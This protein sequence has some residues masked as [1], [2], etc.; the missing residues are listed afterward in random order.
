MKFALLLVPLLLCA[1][2]PKVQACRQLERHGKRGEA[3]ACF[4]KLTASPDPYL[5]AE[6]HYG[7]GNFKVA[8]EDFAAA[9][10]RNPKDANVKVRFGRMM[11]EPFNKNY[12]DGGDL[13]REALEID[14]KNAEALYGLA[15]TA[16]NGFESKA[17][18][19]A[20][21]AL[22]S[23]PKM[24]E[25]QELLAQLA[26]E[27]VD[28]K[29]AV[30]EADKAIKM[31][32]D[33][34]DAYA[35]RAAVEVLEDRSP[36]QWLKKIA[37]VNP[38]YGEGHAIVA[39]HLQLNRRYDDG[40]AYYRKA[41]E[42]DPELLE[43]RSQLGINL[44]R[45]GKEVEA[46]EQLQ[47]AYDAGF[48]ESSTTNSLKLIDSYKKFVTYK[49]PVSILKLDKKEADVL[50]I[51]F[52]QELL[53][54]ISTYDKKYKV[55]LPVPVQLEVYPN[56]EDFAVRTMG[57]PGLGAL[58]VTFGTVVAMD[59]PSGRKPGAFHWAGTLWHEMSHVYVLSATR[60][61][62]PRWFTEGVAVHEESAI[63]P[64][65]GDR[66]TPDIIM[67]V[68]DK[69][70]LPVAE[71]DRG[72]IRPNYPN[73]VIVSYYQ[74]GQII[75][76]I[77]ER[78]GWDKVLAMMN[79]FAA[80]KS[81]P[82]TVQ[83]VLGL[84]PE[85]FDKQFLVWLDKSVKPV[86]DNFDNW[87]KT[88]RSAVGL[89]KEKKYDEAIAEGEKAIGMYK[90]YVEGANAYEIVSESALAKG[91]KKKAMDVLLRYATIGGR[92]PDTLKKLAGL[93][94]EA[95]DMKGAA[96][97]LEKVNYIYPIKDD[98]MHKRLGT[99]YLML[100]N[101]TSAVRE[102]NA[103][104]AEKPNDKA[105][106]HYHLARAFQAA[107]QPDKAEEHVLEALETAPGFR[108]AQKLLLELNAIKK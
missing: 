53:K 72:F 104:L 46:R 34:L 61:R 21:E 32:P 89:Q 14:K 48:K 66:L 37:A 95:G 18:E 87:R 101:P 96:A 35:V 10:K 38:H 19:F 106:A 17:S 107:R 79:A 20:R 36:D 60:H 105:D 11:I 24:V 91:D 25:A 29:K 108:P 30:E 54:C 22:A 2:D 97:T 49:T 47:A 93:Q 85:E 92:T 75:D 77:K 44:M 103:W 86:V 50:R 33:A 68:K 88:L 102:F 98:T 71:L 82:E 7:L 63:Y 69:K 31:S 1:M 67:A 52:E 45:M 56:H 28:F 5:R 62:V 3:K 42:L 80:R 41:L 78:W 94:E 83:E 43:A 84:A 4:S 26:L 23:D 76:Y 90:D 81:T 73:Q 39:H 70:L 65:W 55:K 9:E 99:M 58:G 59:S 8:K 40:I 13:F 57:M 64:E 12:Q 74:A 6:G 15:L 51:Y 100:N 27:D 16:S